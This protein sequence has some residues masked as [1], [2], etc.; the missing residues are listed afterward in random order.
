METEPKPPTPYEK[1]SWVLMALA[2]VFIL[3]FKL[4]PALLAGLLVY[5]LIH[6][7]ARVFSGRMM[8]HHRAKLVAVTLIGLV[9]SCT[10]AAAVLLLIGFL[11]GKIGDLPALLNKMAAIVE[12]VRERTGWE[13][14]P[15]ADGMKDALVKTLREHAQ[16]L[17]HAGGEV[18][19]VV[20][21]TLIGIVIGA[22]AAFEM[23]RPTAPLSSALSERLHRLGEAFEKVVFAQVRISGLNAVFTGI[24]LLVVLPIFGVELPL[25]KTLVVITFIVGLIPVLGN[26]VSNSA[27]VIIALGTSLGAAVASLTFLVVI[28]KLEYF[29][30]ARIVG[31]QIKAKAWEILVAMICCE[32]AFGLSGVIV[33]PI[34]YAYVKKELADRGLI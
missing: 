9:L 14:L 25:R 2:F 16:E 22:L 23:G 27:I 34:A 12:N 31:G 18:G 26:L 11:Q 3:Q 15:A 13:F 7:L 4:L 1:A 28:H 33:A 19:H 6:A 5:S 21:H 24:F 8:S 17:E 29:L 32:A 20:V 10:A 30:N